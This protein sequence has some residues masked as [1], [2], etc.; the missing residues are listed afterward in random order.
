MHRPHLTCPVALM[1]RIPNFLAALF[2]FLA[3]CV[4]SP[5]PPGVPGTP[6]GKLSELSRVEGEIAYPG[7]ANLAVH[8]SF[9]G[10]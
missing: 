3:A 2:V 6:H 10:P 7:I 1:A 8:T 5:P 9:G 4:A